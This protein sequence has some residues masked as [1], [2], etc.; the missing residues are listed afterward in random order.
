MTPCL[1][2]DIPCL[3]CSRVRLTFMTNRNTAGSDYIHANY[4]KSPFLKRDYILTQGPKK[5][6]IADFWRMIW[7][8]KSTAIVMLCQFVETQREKCVEYFPRNANCTL[9]FDKLL[10]TY[11]E[12]TVNKSMVTTRLRLHYEGESRLITH[13]QWKEWPD[14]QVPGSSEVMLKILRKVRARGTPPVIHCAAGVGR[15]GTIMAV[16]IALQAIN[17]F[18]Q[19]PDIKQVTGSHQ[20]HATDLV[21]IVSDLRTTGRASSVQTLQQYMLIWKVVLDFGVSNKLISEESV[22]KFAST[23][24]RS[25]RNAHSS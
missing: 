1:I 10:L 11:E 23:Y 22:G 17:S 25:F 12:S 19:L 7:Q 4:I 16:E 8:E 2:A 20:S 9:R 15:S 5:E 24:R 3:D 18:F 14:Y 21:Q 13:L 6:T